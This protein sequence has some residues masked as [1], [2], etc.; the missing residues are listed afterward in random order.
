MYSRIAYAALVAE[1]TEN[2]AVK[3]TQFFPFT[4][5][6][7]VTKYLS[8]PSVGIIGNRS[9]KIRPIKDLIDGPSGVL[10]IQIEPKKIGYFL[11]GIYGA[12][13]SGVYIPISAASGAFTVG[14]TVTGASG[15][16]AVVVACSNELDYLLCSTVGALV[17]GEQITGGL[18]SKTAT[19]GTYDASVYGHEFK[20]PQTS[21]PTFTLEIGLEN[22]AYR[23]SGVRFHG[24]NSIGFDDNII[25]AEIAMTARAEFKHA[26]VT[27]ILASGAGAKSISVDQTTGLATGDTIKV[28]RPSTGAFL[29]FSAASVKT[30]TIG[31]LAS[32]TAIPVT[33]LET[34]L[35][36]GDLIVL[37]P[38]T[39]S[40]TVGQEFS[41]IGGSVAKIATTP[42]LA[43]AAAAASIEEFELSLQNE[44]ESRHAAN[45]LNVI[46]RFPAKNHLKK[47]SGGGKI[48]QAYENPT[49]LDIMRNATQLAMQIKHT[50]AII[51]ATALYNSLE[52]RIPYAIMAPFN[53]QIEKDGLLDNEVSFDIYRSSSDG[54][55]HKALLINDVTSY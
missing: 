40:Y 14:E 27:A 18:S 49:W 3:P 24:F 4:K 46:N 5:F 1:T 42:T 51:G 7:V 55:T 45:G 10:G 34:A 54:Y 9:D 21:L 20:A 8:K 36:V 47:L 38:Q 28:F 25:T 31:T 37:A 12:V 22:E 15:K 17:I 6:D 26:R 52:W 30:H 41:W 11:K 32:E 13:L 44:L 43:I 23:F 16:T 19:V 50:A 53:P 2:T 29:D 39:P 33:N 35:A 48:K